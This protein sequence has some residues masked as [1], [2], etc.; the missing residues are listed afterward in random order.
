VPGD[1]AQ[2]C[3]D[4]VLLQRFWDDPLCHHLITAAFVEAMAE[5]RRELLGMGAEL[6]RPILLLEAGQDIVVDP[7]GSEALWS[8]VREDLLERHRMEGFLHEVLHDVRRSEAEELVEAWLDRIFP[9]R[10]GTPGAAGAML[11]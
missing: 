6:D 4:P 8:G 7:D 10:A 1:K 9:V 3:N 11:N 2:V 5:G